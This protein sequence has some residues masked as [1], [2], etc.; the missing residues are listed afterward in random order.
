MRRTETVDAV[1]V[2][3]GPAGLAATAALAGHGFTV[4]LIDE[5]PAVGGQIW[6]G[7][8]SGPTGSTALTGARE[9][10]VA[11]TAAEA[12]GLPGVAYAA[13]ATVIDAR[14][15]G[16]TGGETGDGAVEVTWLAS[17]RTSGAGAPAAPSR[18]LHDTRARALVVATG[19]AERPLLFPGA[20]L[21]GVMGVGAVQGAMKQSRLVPDGPGVVLAGHGPLLALTLRQIR[22]LGGRPDAVLDLAPAASSP[23]ARLALAGDLVRAARADP[24]LL[25]RGIALLSAGRG[26]PRH[27]DV[28]ALRAHG[29]RAVEGISFESGGERHELPCRLLAV[30]DG[31]VPNV[32]L[33]RLLGL[34]HRWHA[35]QQAFVPVTGETG[36]A[37]GRAV[38]I[39]GDGGGIAGAPLATSRGRLA[40]L[41]VVLALRASTVSPA[42]EA[43]VEVHRLRRAIARRLPARRL[44]DRLYPALPIGRHA[45][46][47]TIVCRCEAVTLETIERAIAAGAIGAN[48]VKTFTRCGMGA[49]QGR[50]CSNA[51]TR[52]VAERLGIEPDV[53][54]A[55]RVRPPLKPTL[56]GDYLAGEALGDAGTPDAAASL[57]PAPAPSANPSA[58]PSAALPGTATAGGRP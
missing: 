27:A 3:A 51:L 18:G 15:G 50:G 12:R 21:P 41:D 29:E 11:R 9:V 46:P 39:A 57:V 25:A 17:G 35:G 6:R 7:A 58:N 38:W 10:R 20:T 33:T 19:A 47:G 4:R 30:H 55:L 36:R 26:V 40:G 14:T 49:C 43:S 22:R 5:Q 42:D 32:Q 24:V 44:V 37:G 48:R 31:V 54:G 8:T 52:I 53:A 23:R 56:I 16:K 13:G 2:G 34:E 28:R 1:I 45:T